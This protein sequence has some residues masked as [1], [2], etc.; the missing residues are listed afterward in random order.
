MREAAPAVLEAVDGGADDRLG[1]A[2]DV[3]ENEGQDPDRE[4]GQPDPQA[5]VDATDPGRRQAEKDGESG[6]RP[7]QQRLSESQRF[8]LRLREP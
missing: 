5:N 7:Q 4:H 6:D 8:Y 3:H 1:M 2:A